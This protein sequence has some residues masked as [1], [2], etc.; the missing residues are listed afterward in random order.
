MR[1][2]CMPPIEHCRESVAAGNLS[3]AGAQ[4]LDHQLVGGLRLT[5]LG[6]HDGGARPVKQ[7]T[8]KPVIHSTNRIAF[9]SHLRHLVGF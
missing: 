4:R 2:D 7:E 5:S 3:L 6:G 1:S 8:S 9:A